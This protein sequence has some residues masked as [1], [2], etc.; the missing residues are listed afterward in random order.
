MADKKS[1][2]FQKGHDKGYAEGFKGEPSSRASSL[3]DFLNTKVQQDYCN[4]LE[5]GY[6]DG[7]KNPNKK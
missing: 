7:Q 2:N 5:K 6:R 1:G 4:G 3:M